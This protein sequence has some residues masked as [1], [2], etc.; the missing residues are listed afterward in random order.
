MLDRPQ[1]TPD[2]W[3][4]VQDPRIA[5]A[6][7]HEPRNWS[8]DMA[9]DGTTSLVLE[10]FCDQGDGLWERSDDELCDLAVRDLAEQLQFI[11]PSEVIGRFAVR[12]RDAYPRYGVGY[13]DATQTIKTYLRSFDNLQIVGRGGTFRYNNTDH[14]I[15]TGLLAAG[16]ILGDAVDVDS[17]NSE[18]AYL[19]ERKVPSEPLR[20]P[21]VDVHRTPSSVK[22]SAG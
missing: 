9:P 18:R 15:E 6:R 17:V 22:V 21:T 7:M 1:V 3:I 20:Q 14:A 16:G 10:F 12:S 4:Y 13:Q 5:F 11:E 19:E 8:D 2:T